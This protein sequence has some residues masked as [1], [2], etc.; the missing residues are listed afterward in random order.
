MAKVCLDAGHFGKY[1]RSPVNCDYYESIQ[2]W[3]LHNL[4]ADALKR[5][6]IEVVKTRKA[7]DKDLALTTRGRMAKG[8]DLFISLHSNA[9]GGKGVDYPL[10][11]VML[12]GSST[13]IGMKLA[14]IVEDQMKT[15]QAAKQ[16]VKAGSGGGEYYGVL[17]GAAAVNVPGLILEHSFHTNP[18]AARWLLSKNKLKRLA[19]AEADCIASYLGAFAPYGIKIARCTALNIRKG[20]GTKYAVCG[21]IEDSKTYTITEEQNGW[22]RLKSG[23][24]W[25][26]LAYTKRV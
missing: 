4:L 15:Q 21:V 6:G 19:E 1:N 3:E 11:I 5:R 10:A 24:G 25:I 20:P 17:R 13:D 2:M 18:N 7:Q 26:S 8:C 9:A 12:D 14:K 16:I 22:G 23:A